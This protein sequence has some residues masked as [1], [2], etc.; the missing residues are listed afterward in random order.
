MKHNVGRGW[1]ALAEPNEDR[2]GVMDVYL[3]H[4]DGA[5]GSLAAAE[6]EGW[7]P[8]GTKV[9]RS[10]IIRTREWI[11]ADNINY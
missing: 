3:E 5:F 8:D 2:E 7:T 1:T 10:V 4:K 9:P 6:M 11:V